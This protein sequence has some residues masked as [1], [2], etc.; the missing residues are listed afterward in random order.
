MKACSLR[1]E[2]AHALYR[3]TSRG[4]WREDI[5]HDDADRQAW[6]SVPGQVCK[7]FNCTVYTYCLVDNHY[8]LLVR[9][10]DT[11]LSAGMRHLHQVFT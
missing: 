7:R 11:N 6:V 10:H 3:V 5:H 8:D 9:T 2:F 4:I 1:L